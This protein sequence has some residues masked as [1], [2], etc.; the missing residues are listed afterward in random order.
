MRVSAAVERTDIATVEFICRE[1]RLAGVQTQHWLPAL[2]AAQLAVGDL[3]G[4]T[5]NAAHLLRHGTRPCLEVAI[6]VAI[7]TSDFAVLKGALDVSAQD[8]VAI[9]MTKAE[10]RDAL[11]CARTTLIGVLQERTAQL[12]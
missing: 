7:R 9:G 5:S 10:S 6:A 12:A 4:A 8:R 1:L 2:V 11:D 3:R